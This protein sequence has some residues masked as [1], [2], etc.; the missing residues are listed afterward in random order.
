MMFF[1]TLIPF[2]HF[3]FRE[4][5]F[6]LRKQLYYYLSK[7]LVVVVAALAFAQWR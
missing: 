5:H 2:F 6:A 7:V 1:I 3:I 4:T